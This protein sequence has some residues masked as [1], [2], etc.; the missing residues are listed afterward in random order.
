[1]ICADCGDEVDAVTVVVGAYPVLYPEVCEFCF[2]I[3][4]R[5]YTR[6]TK[7]L[8]R[9]FRA[10]IANVYVPQYV[11]DDGQVKEYLNAWAAERKHQL[12]IEHV[13]LVVR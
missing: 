6:V 9:R 4:E 10:A 12:L 13:A 7:T 2:G 8:P 1:M 3:R 5:R 11:I